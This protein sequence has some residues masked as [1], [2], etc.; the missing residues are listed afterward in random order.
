MKRSAVGLLKHA[1]RIHE[2]TNR[3]ERQTPVSPPEEDEGI[4][5]EERRAIIADIDEVASRNRLPGRA[6]RSSPVPS[7]KGFVFPLVVNVLAVVLTVAVVLSLALIFRQKD[8]VIA[9]GNA[10]VTTA[11]GKLIQE[12]KRDSDSKLREKDKAIA[13]IQGRLSSIDRQRGELVASIERRIKARESELRAELESELEKERGRLAGQGL[14]EA[15]IQERIKKFEAQKNAEFNRRIEEYRKR[16]EEE[17]AVEEARLAQARDEYQRSISGLNEERKKIL[18][19]ARKSEDRLRTSLEARARELEGQ[20]AAAQAMAATARTEL[21]LLEE[22]RAKAQSAEERILGL[23]GAIRVA[24]RDR[25]FDD[26][27]S[28]IAALDSYLSD[29]SVMAV[30]SLKPRREADLFIAEAL[31]SLARTELERSSVDVNKLLGQAELLASVREAAA[32][33][34][35]ALKAG[36][37]ATAAAKYSVA[38][39]AVPEILA[40]HDYFLASEK[41]ARAAAAARLKSALEEGERA[42]RSGDR[43]ECSRR[44]A[45]ALAALPL[46]EAQREVM[47]A[48]LTQPDAKATAAAAKASDSAA[49]RNSYAAAKRNLAAGKW[50][51]SIALFV[52]LVGAYPAAEQV[53]DAL[54]GIEAARSGME[55]DSA[56][57]AAAYEK[58]IA[59][60]RAEAGRSAAS[61]RTDGASL[62][63][64]LQGAKDA[65]ASSERKLEES[66]AEV[67]SLQRRLEAAAVASAEASA[68]SGAVDAKTAAAASAA[69]AADAAALQD[70]RTR[71]KA[72]QAEYDDYLKADG[73]VSSK[74]GDFAVVERR[75]KLVA[76]LGGN[77]VK[78][79]FPELAGI[80]DSQ[81]A[82]Y[83]QQLSM[84]SLRTA[85]DIAIQAATAKSDKE[86]Q[87]TLDANAKHYAEDRTVSDFILALRE[88][89]K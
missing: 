83:R 45:E 50:P 69:A 63:A 5:A 18:D 87:A 13:D 71:A 72:L 16:I 54:A 25:R 67:A 88:L 12:I 7:R 60:L 74:G 24:L 32:A 84:E 34:N 61:L 46:E 19:E 68:K 44:Y 22:Q 41:E 23:Y 1:S 52:G 35:K 14:S 79:L 43:G 51:E 76:F 33:G 85:A 42:W 37:L 64:A 10:V 48:R 70:L 27:L 39:A 6:A 26:A 3:S 20:S 58:T 8:Q 9:E 4:T 2:R 86:K 89:L 56:E 30:P 80:V 53:P 29:P 31:E 55:R 77:E 75:K 62:D 21:R 78:S 47:L 59:D 73:A 38:L 49:A 82:D 65:L 11:E 81:F 36:D 66:R 15:A 57:R 40:A 28:S 17:R